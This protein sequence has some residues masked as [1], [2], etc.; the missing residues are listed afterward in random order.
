VRILFAGRDNAFNR[1]VINWLHERFTVAA[2]YF[3]E[4]DRFSWS[5]R[6]RKTRRR[7]RRYGWMAAADELAFHVADRLLIRRGETSLW[8]SRV[9]IAFRRS[10][11]LDVPTYVVE[12]VHAETWLAKTNEIAPD[13]VLST[14]GSVIFKKSFYSIPTMGTFVLHEGLTPEYKGL[15]T[16]LWAM[17]KREPEYIGYTLLRVNDTIDGG[18][19]LA[20]ARYHLQPDEN[21]SH[22]SYV[23]HKAIID[24]LPHI[25][26]ALRQLDTDRSFV[27]LDVSHRPTNY[28]SWMRLSEFLKYYYHR[29][30]NRP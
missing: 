29:N 30:G 6:W 3:L 22:W 17:L 28:Y 13:I 24:N 26:A 7:A 5:A 21:V 4:P 23:G 9:P 14:C 8:Q 11:R 18:E 12:N 1:G 20:Q 2:V 19:V 27:P 25:E 16:P 10:Q 15:H